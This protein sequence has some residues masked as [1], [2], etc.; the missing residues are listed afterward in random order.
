M[1]SATSTSSRLLHVNFIA[2]AAPDIL[3]CGTEALGS[4]RDEHLCQ[5]CE[6]SGSEASS[7]QCELG[8]VKLRYVQNAEPQNDI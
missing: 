3:I 7:A 8:L 4:T 6:P 5:L 2:Q 1:N